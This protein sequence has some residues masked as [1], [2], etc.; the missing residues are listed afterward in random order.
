MTIAVLIFFVVFLV[1]VLIF[2][3]MLLAPSS[4][5]TE[6][7]SVYECGFNNVH[8]PRNTFSIAFYI[9]AILFLIFDLELAIFYPIAV[10]MSIVSVYGIIVGLFFIAILTIGFVYE[11]GS[12]AL[13]ISTE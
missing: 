11:Y 7:I 3:S 6:K 4:P 9:V 10:C 2:I 5:N 8:S 1:I 13:K 12:Q